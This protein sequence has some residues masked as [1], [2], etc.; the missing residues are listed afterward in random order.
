MSPRLG[1]LSILLPHIESNFHCRSCTYA[2]NPGL[3]W[4]VSKPYSSKRKGITDLDS[5]PFFK[6]VN[7]SILVHPNPTSKWD[8]KQHFYRSNSLEIL[9]AKCLQVRD[10]IFPFARSGKVV[11]ICKAYL[12]NIIKTLCLI[13]I[14]W[15]NDAKKKLWMQEL[16]N[17]TNICA[18]FLAYG[19]SSG[20]KFLKWPA[21]EKSSWM[22]TIL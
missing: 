10:G 18:L 1:Q 17:N 22:R 2:F 16:K 15:I 7:T 9:P 19:M 11:T 4:F 5:R 6:I 21:D 8:N 12:Q 13:E 3:I 14:S 20:A